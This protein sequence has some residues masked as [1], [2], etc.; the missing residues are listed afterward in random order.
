MSQYVGHSETNIQLQVFSELITLYYAM[1]C[2]AM[3][4]IYI[5]SV[6]SNDSTEL[7]TLSSKVLFIILTH[8]FVVKLRNL[9]LHSDQNTVV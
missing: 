4:I 6:R 5:F 9:A 1:L 2:Y 8:T 3:L 7:L